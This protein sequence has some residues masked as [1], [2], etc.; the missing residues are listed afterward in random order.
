MDGKVRK[1]NMSSN[2][3]LFGENSLP[4]VEQLRLLDQKMN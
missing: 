4:K 1:E 3:L 2:L